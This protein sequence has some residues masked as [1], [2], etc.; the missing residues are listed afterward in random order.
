MVALLLGPKRSAAP[1]GC[2]L[3]VCVDDPRIIP[4]I[5]M[6]LVLSSLTS[7]YPY[8][9][10]LRPV[11]VRPGPNAWTWQAL[12][13]MPVWRATLGGALTSALASMISIATRM[14]PGGIMLFDR[15]I[16]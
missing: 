2:P 12:H 5:G 14:K 16:A 9:L 10:K 7:V 3:M 15:I 4:A 11:G 1:P 13:G 6:N 8:S